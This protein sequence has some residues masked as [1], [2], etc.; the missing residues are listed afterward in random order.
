MPLM[1]LNVANLGFITIEVSSKIPKDQRGHQA[2]QFVMVSPEQNEGEE[3]W[4]IHYPGDFENAFFWKHDLQGKA[5]TPRGVIGAWSFAVP[6]MDVKVLGLSGW[7]PFEKY[8]KRDD[9]FEERSD[10]RASHFAYGGTKFPGKVEALVAATTGHGTRDLMAFHSGGPIVAQHRGPDQP[11]YSRHVFDIDP[12]GNLDME[13]HAGF[14]G[15]FIVRHWLGAYCQPSGAGAPVGGAGLGGQGSHQTA[16]PQK[17]VSPPPPPDLYAV[18]LNASFSADTSGY[19]GT[20]FSDAEAVESREKGGPLWRATKIH[21]HGRTKDGVDVRGGAIWMDALFNY[22]D[23]YDMPWQYEL[24]D[25]VPATDGFFPLKVHYRRNLNLKHQ[26]CNEDRIGRWDWEVFS[27]VTS[28][29]PCTYAQ[30]KSTT[31]GRPNATYPP[32][33]PVTGLTQFQGPGFI[34][35]P[36]VGI[37]RGKPPTPLTYV[38]P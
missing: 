12:D 24:E 33:A 30:D 7:K 3:D 11:Q 22:G 27:P 17:P 38:N 6:A 13:R 4:N 8:G 31:S 16:V 14:H 28:L 20:H 10:I 37:L 5:T 9:D 19:L 36:R 21:S 23:G 26:W 34:F 32:T 18:L 2:M 1:P 25:Y 15:P 29:P 35:Q